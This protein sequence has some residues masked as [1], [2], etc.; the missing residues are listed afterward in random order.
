MRKIFL[1][2]ITATLTYSCSIKPDDFVGVHTSY[3][4]TS[5]VFVDTTEIVQSFFQNT[6]LDI[7]SSKLAPIKVDI[8]KNGEELKGTISIAYYS[9]RENVEDGSKISENKIDL[10]N[11]HIINDT[12]VC[13]TEKKLLFFLNSSDVKI[14][15]SGSEFH[16]ILNA[17]KGDSIYESCNKFVKKLSSKSIAYNCVSNLD[18]IKETNQC[19]AEKRFNEMSTKYNKDKLEYLKALLSSHIK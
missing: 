13:E 6:Y 11:I 15:K 5:C 12:L 7:E 19:I 17:T 1:I 4:T 18:Y 3:K 10:N 8:F 16:I 2:I 14:S 9:G